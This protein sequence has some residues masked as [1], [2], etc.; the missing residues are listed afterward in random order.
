MSDVASA[1]SPL[2]ISVA[3]ARIV[4]AIFSISSG[5]GKILTAD[6]FHSL[7]SIATPVDNMLLPALSDTVE[8]AGAPSTKT[9]RVSFDSSFNDA[10]IFN[11]SDT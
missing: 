3:V 1:V 4:K 5:A 2:L 10:M 6:K 8:P 11:T 7:T 9:L